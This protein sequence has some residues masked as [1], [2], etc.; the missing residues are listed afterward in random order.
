MKMKSCFRCGKTEKEVR[1]FDAI[2]GTEAVH[3]CEKCAIIE[4][5]PLLKKPSTKQLKEAERANSVYT[6]LKRLAG[7]KTRDEQVESFMERLEKVDE[8]PLS[9]EES[10]KPLNFIDNF[11]WHIQRARRNKGLSVKQL[12]WALG[13][14]ESA[15]NMIEKA[16]IPEDAEK[17]IRKLEQFFQIKLRERTEQEKQKEQEKKERLKEKSKI[18]DIEKEEAPI[19]PIINEPEIK[20]EDIIS[21]ASGKDIQEEDIDYERVSEKREDK[22]EKQPSQVLTFKPKEMQNLKIADLKKLKQ[23]QEREDN[24]VEVEKQRKDSLIESQAQRLLEQAD[25][26]EQRSE[27]AKKKVAEE[28]KS[29]ALGQEQESIKDKKDILNKKLKEISEKKR[30]EKG[31]EKTKPAEVKRKVPS[32]AELIDRKRQEIS[33]KDEKEKGKDNLD[34]KEDSEIEEKQEER[35]S[36][37]N[38]SN[39]Y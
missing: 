30:K 22:Q 5:I 10:D 17:L 18:P 39:N 2:H 31:V 4:G 21:I 37:N 15:I 29:Q 34:I 8:T 26:E 19:K 33:N 20:D 1:L 3:S 16:E 27:V 7:M 24:L 13:E 32:I 38:N 14:S 9:K 35:L 28:M 36:K 12:A 6:R 25:E 11:H 23:E